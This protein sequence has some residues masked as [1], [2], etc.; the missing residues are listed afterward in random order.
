MAKGAC[1][2]SSGSVHDNYYGRRPVAGGTDHDAANEPGGEGTIGVGPAANVNGSATSASQF[3][4]TKARSRSV[5]SR[6][7]RTRA[8]RVLG[9][10]CSGVESSAPRCIAEVGMPDASTAGCRD[11]NPMERA[12]LVV[13]SVTLVSLQAFTLDRASRKI[14]RIVVASSSRSP[15]GAQRHEN[16]PIIGLVGPM[17]G[18]HRVSTRSMVNLGAS[19]PLD[20][21]ELLCRT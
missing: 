8:L 20:L 5:G 2:R 10:D 11:L 1:Q 17:S 19:W 15:A 4:R 14:R 13:D 21:D 9:S 3:D 12:R 6:P 16:Q 7:V 18:D